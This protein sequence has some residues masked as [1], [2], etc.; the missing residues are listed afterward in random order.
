MAS[1]SGDLAWKTRIF[2]AKARCR[3]SMERSRLDDN[4]GAHDFVF[5][6]NIKEPGH[7]SGDTPKL[8]E[9]HAT[10]SQ[11][12]NSDPRLAKMRDRLWFQ[13]TT[14]SNDMTAAV[15]RI[16]NN[17]ADSTIIKAMVGREQDRGMERFIEI[18]DQQLDEAIDYVDRLPAEAK[19]EVANACINIVDDFLVFWDDYCGNPWG[20]SHHIH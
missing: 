19:D 2:D 4:F 8:E 15:E 20:H 9:L 16:K 11:P 18:I 5:G 3:G 10:K 17:D 7:L 12:A 1:S 13:F 14:A 6:T